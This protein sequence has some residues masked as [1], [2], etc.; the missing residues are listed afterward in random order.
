M[1]RM[2]MA[3]IGSLSPNVQETQQVLGREIMDVADASD[4]RLVENNVRN[5]QQENL[6]KQLSDEVIG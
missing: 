5:I 1:S 6:S 2:F 4:G 3:D